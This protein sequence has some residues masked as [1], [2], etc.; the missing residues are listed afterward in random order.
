MTVK[1]GQPAIET[2]ADN[3]VVTEYEVA[4]DVVE[5]Y[6]AE[7]R[8][9]ESVSQYLNGYPV[10]LA[11]F[12]RDPTSGP[13][14]DDARELLADIVEGKMPPNK[15]GRPP[16]RNGRSTHAIVLD[17]FV[18]WGR[19]KKYRLKCRQQ[20]ATGQRNDAPKEAACVAVGLGHGMTATAVRRLIDR[21][22]TDDPI[23]FDQ[24][25]KLA[26]SKLSNP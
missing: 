21:L 9:M 17:F 26:T 1:I 19:Q 4:K 11:S 22:R 12:L 15:V 3:D 2:M 24:L 5:K 6:E 8:C 18:E 20:P 16:E 25:Q 23:A 13:I 7:C 14:S 10:P